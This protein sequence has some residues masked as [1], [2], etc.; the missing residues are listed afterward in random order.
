M[1]CLDRCSQIGALLG[2]LLLIHRW[3]AVIAPTTHMQAEVLISNPITYRM[4]E[5][6]VRW[7]IAARALKLVHLQHCAVGAGIAWHCSAVPA[8][9]HYPQGVLILALNFRL[10]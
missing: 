2:K 10:G 6:H 9:E 1:V 8:S 4:P 7:S 5:N 3:G